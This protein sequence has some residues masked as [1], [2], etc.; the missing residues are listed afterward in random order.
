VGKPKEFNELLDFDR[1]WDYQQ[2]DVTEQKFR[3]LLAAK[4]R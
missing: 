3:D 1:L 2:P 4:C